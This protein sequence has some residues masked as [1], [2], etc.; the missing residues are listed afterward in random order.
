MNYIKD[1]L[2]FGQITI[3]YI[4]S[5]DELV[6]IMNLVIASEPFYASLS[7]LAMSDIYSPT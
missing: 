3:P 4:N 2:D 1:N 7:K 6:D 5:A